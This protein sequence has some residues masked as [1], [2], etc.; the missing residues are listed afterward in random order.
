MAKAPKRAF[1]CNECGADYPRWQGQCSACHAWNTITEMRIAASPQVARNE[2]LSGYAGNAGVSKVQKLSDISLEALPRFSTGFKEFDPRAGRRRGAGQRDPD[3]R[4][5]R[6]GQ[7]DAAA[8]NPL[9]NWR[10]G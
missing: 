7:I 1:V 8:A 5:P 4:Q 10:K 2:R 9:Q 3:W 6:R